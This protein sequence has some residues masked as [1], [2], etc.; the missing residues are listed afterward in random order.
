MKAMVIDDNK[1]SVALIKLQLEE[2]G[3]GCEGFTCALEAI[4]TYSCA[5]YDFV[6]TDFR[7]PVLNGL[8]VIKHLLDQ[9][10][11]LPIVLISCEE[12]IKN[13]A[14]RH[15][16]YAFLPKPLDVVKLSQILDRLSGELFRRDA[17]RNAEN[18]A[19]TYLD[20]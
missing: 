1:A 5:H 8:Q 19:P 10:E 3:H 9:G 2:L 13:E 17:M 12:D 20:S 7:M 15:G 18:D 6:I 16:A 4:K 14:L 11:W